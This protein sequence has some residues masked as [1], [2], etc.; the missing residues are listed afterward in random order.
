[1]NFACVL[2]HF[3]FKQQGAPQ[4]TLTSKVAALDYSS[5][6]SMKLKLTCLLNVGAGA[7]FFKVSIT[8][9]K[10]SLLKTTCLYS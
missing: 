10:Q 6:E 2:C 3:A 8:I 9:L 5:I 7:H 1:M 4:L